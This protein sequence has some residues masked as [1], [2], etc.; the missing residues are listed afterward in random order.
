MMEV[1]PGNCFKPSLLDLSNCLFNN[2]VFLTSDTMSDNEF[3][4]AQ[5]SSIRRVRVRA[6][7]MSLHPFLS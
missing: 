1:Y 3:P 7:F 4:W 2:K 5:F 6:P